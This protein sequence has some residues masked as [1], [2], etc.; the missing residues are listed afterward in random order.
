MTTLSRCAQ[1]EAVVNIHWPA[2]MV[3]RAILPQ[4]PE[5]STP[6]VITPDATRQAGT[7][8]APLQPGWIVAYRDES[9]KLCGGCEDKG[10]GTV[11]ECRW[12]TGRWSVWLTDGQ[13]VP[14]YSIRSV[15][16]TNLSG[17][18]CA[19]WT[20]REHAVDGNGKPSH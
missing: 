9:G 19:A 14:L 12:D 3:C 11:Q 16:K 17:R 20:V 1:C 6:P 13:R 18:I 15:G 2:C 10:H 4:A 5:L 7:P 8:I